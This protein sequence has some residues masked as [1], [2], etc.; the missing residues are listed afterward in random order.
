VEET[1]G[2]GIHKRHRKKRI[3]K[4]VHAIRNMARYGTASMGPQHQMIARSREPFRFRVIDSPR[5][6]D[7]KS[8][9]GRGVGALMASLFLVCNFY[10]FGCEGKT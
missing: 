7:R 1:A 4:V 2:V 9:P 6:P 5:V 3:G 10:L 8:K